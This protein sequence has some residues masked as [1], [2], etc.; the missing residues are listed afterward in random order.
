MIIMILLTGLPIISVILL[1]FTNYELAMP[2]GSVRWIGLRNY[3][4]L[5]FGHNRVFYYSLAISVGMTVAATAVQMVLGFIAASLLNQNIKFKALAVGCLIVPIAITP[6][7]ASQIWK[8]MLN[9]EFGVINFILYGLFG[10]TVVWLGPDNALLS[11]FIVNIWIMTPF[12]TLILY[13]GLTS[14]P[15]E[16]FESAAI[17]GAN[18]V[19]KLFRITL[20]MLKPLILLTILFRSI[21][22]L[23]MFDIPFVLTHGGPGNITEFVGLHIWRLGFGVSTLV[24]RASAVSVVLL[25]IV[26]AIS[27]TLI[28]LMARKED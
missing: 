3:E 5:F 16:P 13:A 14:L 17:D 11:V 28:K 4:R 20:P 2:W 7:I 10:T 21:D 22:M 23:R 24:G 6:S 18:A 1:S 15:L 9:A 8:L 27:L 25:I 26:S 12:V 19:Q